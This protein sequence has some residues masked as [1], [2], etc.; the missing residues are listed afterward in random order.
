MEKKGQVTIFIIL[1]ILLLV[2]TGVMFYFKTLTVTETFE[3]E[4]RPVVATVPQEFIAI[5]EYTETCLSSISEQGIKILGQQGGH[6]YPTEVGSYSLIDPTNSD[7]IVLG[8]LSVPYWHYN[9]LP[10]GDP[11]V[12]VS[13]L[14]PALYLED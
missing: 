8:S 4:G 14:M 12:S 11:A 6:I 13:S 7:G 2:I 3:T 1:G 9:S 5:Q 10:N